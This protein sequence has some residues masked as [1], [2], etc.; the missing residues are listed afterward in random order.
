MDRRRFIRPRQ[1]AEIVDRR[2]VAPRGQVG[3]DGRER[4]HLHAEKI[5]V[6]VH[7]KA[8]DRKIIAPLVVGQVPFRA[9][10]DPFDRPAG[11][12]RRPQNQ[13]LF[14]IGAAAQAETA[15][16]VAGD[17]ADI[18]F[19]DAENLGR[20]LFAQLVGIMQTRIERV[21]A[22][23]RLVA[24][25]AR[26]RL[27]GVGDRAGD[28]E[29]ALDHDFGRLERR[30]GLVRI[31]ALDPE[32]FVARAIVPHQRRILVHRVFGAGDGRQK[33]IVHRDRLGRIL[34]GVERCRD[35][36]DD[37]V[38]DIAYPADRQRG[39][40][41][42]VLAVVPARLAEKI[43]E[44]V[45]NVILTGQD[46]EHARQCRRRRCVDGQDPGM[47][48]GRAQ[49]VAARLAR[50]GDIVGIS[51]AAGQKPRIFRPRDRLADIVFPHP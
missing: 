7:R 3:A 42:L 28:A 51:A 32:T 13:Y 37:R 10:G 38:A 47:R 23:R 36:E 18:L 33:L 9:V 1:R 16:D 24:A 8:G 46:R 40:G 50:Q 27:D 11:P 30:P 48:M 17:H 6:P 49:H 5:A 21:A 45:G 35:D 20:E 41:I 15:A 22:V 25:E 29:R 39:A 44:P 19:G 14:G 34:R 4:A 43:A 31:A 2:P 12:P 26:A